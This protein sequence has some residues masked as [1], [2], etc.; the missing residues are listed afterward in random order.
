MI[1][2]ELDFILYLQNNDIPAVGPIKS[3]NDNFV[4]SFKTKDGLYHAVS[5]DHIKGNHKEYNELSKAELFKWGKGLAELHIATMN[6][7]PKNGKVRPTWEDEIKLAL[8]TYPDGHNLINE[9]LQALK[10]S[11]VNQGSIDDNFGL[12][13]YDFELDNLIWNNGSYKIIDFDDC[14]Y[15]PLVADIAYGIPDI[16]ECN[17]DKKEFMLNNFIDGY[18]S[19]LDLPSKWREELNLFHKLMLFL[20]YARVLRSYREANPA[21]DLEWTAKMRAR[22]MEWLSKRKDEL[23]K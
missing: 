9:K 14:A 8:K 5:F 23:E 12:I 3:L 13:H 16:L 21:T 18:N 15:Y 2:A 17:S 20:K 19:K 10:E 7:K 11:I 1:E 4:E 6:Y 22:H